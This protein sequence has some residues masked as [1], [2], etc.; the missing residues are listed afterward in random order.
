MHERPFNSITAHEASPNVQ[1]FQLCFI[2]ISIEIDISSKHSPAN[3]RHQRILIWILAI[4]NGFF[5]FHQQD[6]AR[7]ATEREHSLQIAL[8]K[9][10]QCLFMFFSL[11]FI[12]DPTFSGGISGSIG[13]LLDWFAGQQRTFFFRPMKQASI[14]HR[15]I[16]SPLSYLQIFRS[17]FFS[18]KRGGSI[19]VS[20]WLNWG[21]TQ[22][23]S[24][25]YWGGLSM[26]LSI[27]R[28]GEL[29]YHLNS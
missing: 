13:T 2:S 18:T 19:L 1:F 24:D 14:V 12:A 29:L 26:S 20:G 11:P 7:N 4:I 17:K 9:H 25:F 6:N 28:Y 5:S 21:G 10:L 8:T 16:I 15:S 23:T 27:I 22:R 3:I